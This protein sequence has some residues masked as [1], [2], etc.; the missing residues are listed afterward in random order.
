MASRLLERQLGRAFGRSEGFDGPLA[1]F[2]AL[3]DATYLQADEERRM[4]EHVSRLSSQELHSAYAQMRSLV[5]ALPDTCVHLA[6]DGMITNCQGSVTQLGGAPTW[7]LVGKHIG[8]TALA[9]VADQLLR[10]AAASH[11]GCDARQIDV[12]L[13]DGDGA[14][15]LEIRVAP[16]DADGCVLIVRDVTM[17]RRSQAHAAQAQKLEAIGQL[18]AGIAHEINTPT[19]YIGDNLRFLRDAF[20]Q[21]EQ[22][23]TAVAAIDEAADPARGLEPLLAARQSLD[24]GFLQ[25]ECPLA[26][27][28]SLDGVER[29]SHI[30][31]SMK[32]FAH[33]DRGEKSA[34]DLNR[35]VSSAT[36]VSRNEWKY[37][38]EL[39]LELGQLP[40]IPAYAGD[41]GQVVLNL[42]V[43]AAH[44]IKARFAGGE[45]AGRITL[46]TLALADRVVL[47]VQDNGSGIAPQHRERVF[48]QFFTTKPVGQG[49]G[50]GL[51]LV[52]RIVVERH[53]GWIT[54]DTREGE[55][56]TFRI[57]L[58]TEGDKLR[59]P[60]APAKTDAALS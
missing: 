40:Q 22:L 36:T 27:T 13:G 37:V 4:N 25:A 42:V 5:N 2:L 32:E 29:V 15:W 26:L 20:A 55:G 18:A 31:Y 49:T 38:A 54:F 24:L 52:R 41:L 21:I 17:Q 11:T 16:T 30:V 9:P 33:P 35:V 57:E 56:T 47:E 51:A 50:Q 58:S 7:S 34:V 46:R 19:Q 8:V 39:Q 44:A 12:K 28:Q 14:S 45:K 48:E 23:L 59:P 1:S 53:G 10:A 6:A 60:L 43:N 3:V